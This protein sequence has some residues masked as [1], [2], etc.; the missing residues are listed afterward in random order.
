MLFLL[1]SSSCLFVNERFS[2]LLLFIVDN[3]GVEPLWF[4][5]HYRETLALYTQR[6]IVLIV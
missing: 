3:N 4:P 5:N 2:G 1:I 6:V